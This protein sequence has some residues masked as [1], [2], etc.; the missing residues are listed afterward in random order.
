MVNMQLKTIIGGIKANE[1][2]CINYSNYNLTKELS[3]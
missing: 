2:T 3:G 1:Y